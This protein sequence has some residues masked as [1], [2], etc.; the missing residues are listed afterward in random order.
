M[1]T[2]VHIT[3]LLV[4]DNSLV[5]MSI[6]Q[7]AVWLMIGLGA[8]INLFLAMIDLGYSGMAD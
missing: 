5:P 1:C 7:T 3:L 6:D 2:I 4:G 8:E